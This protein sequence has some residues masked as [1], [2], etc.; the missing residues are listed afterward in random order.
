MSYVYGYKAVVIGC[1]NWGD[2]EVTSQE[3]EFE[4]YDNKQYAQEVA[5]YE[6][7]KHL[8]YHHYTV[9]LVKKVRC[10]TA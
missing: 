9:G 4:I 1:D 2:E 5:D 8:H 10:Y 3:Y 7:E 6:A